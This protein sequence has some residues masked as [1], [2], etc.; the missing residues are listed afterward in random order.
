M[1]GEFKEIETFG[2]LLGFGLHDPVAQTL[3]FKYESGDRFFIYTDGLVENVNA[4]EELLEST[5]L[6]RI[7]NQNRHRTSLRDFKESIIS[8]IISFYGKSEFTDDAMFLA[9]EIE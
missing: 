3:S 7:L 4:K 2:T 5:G 8:E 1:R 9:F 6:L